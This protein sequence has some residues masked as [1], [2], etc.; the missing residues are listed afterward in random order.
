MIMMQSTIYQKIKVSVDGLRKI[1]LLFNQ[2]RLN[3]FPVQDI[4]F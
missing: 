1:F 2:N 4:G 3:I